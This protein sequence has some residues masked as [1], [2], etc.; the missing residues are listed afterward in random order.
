MLKAVVK[1]IQKEEII[2][3]V[4]FNF[5]GNTLKMLSLELDD[6]IKVGTKVALC[7]KSTHITL[8]K[9]FSGELS[10]SNQIKANIESVENGKLLSSVRLN[11]SGDIQEAII[12]SS[13]SLKMDLKKDDEVIVLMK[14]SEIS[15]KEVL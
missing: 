6:S 14:A 13:A 1:S 12:T 7:I 3:L 11:L 5:H 15:I 10:C 9:S 4:E 2:H 8:A